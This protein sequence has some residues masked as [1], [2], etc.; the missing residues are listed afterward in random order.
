[1]GNKAGIRRVASRVTTNKRER[2]GAVC[3]SDKAVGHQRPAAFLFSARR[4]DEQSVS[5]W[6]IYILG[7][8]NNFFISQCAMTT[9]GARCSAS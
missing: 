3:E 9:S 6:G 5:V 2:S 4:G 7:R 1:M 8:V